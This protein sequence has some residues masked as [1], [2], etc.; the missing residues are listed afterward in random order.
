M[1][2]SSCLPERSWRALLRSSSIPARV[3]W[4]VWTWI[5]IWRMRLSIAA[6]SVERRCDRLRRSSSSWL[7]R[8]SY[9]FSDSRSWIWRSSIWRWIASCSGVEAARIFSWIVTIGSPGGQGGIRADLQRLDQAAADRLDRHRLA[10]ERQR[11]HHQY[12]LGGEQGIDQH[13]EGRDH[14]QVDRPVHDHVR[15]RIEQVAGLDRMPQL[16]RRDRVDLDGPAFLGGHRLF[17]NLP[18]FLT[19][20]A[21]GRG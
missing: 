19:L 7:E 13:R 4:A 11:C 10:L 2:N 5:S 18:C 12:V 3:R 16:A 20:P 15:R 17:R 14:H 21:G 6:C 8:N 9:S 1:A